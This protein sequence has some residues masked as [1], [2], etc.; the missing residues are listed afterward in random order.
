MHYLICAGN[1][2]DINITRRFLMARLQG[3][4][5]V[6]FDDVNDKGKQLPLIINGY[7]IILDASQT[8]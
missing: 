1:D 2:K 6:N 4:T 3:R 8:I 5:S 7:A